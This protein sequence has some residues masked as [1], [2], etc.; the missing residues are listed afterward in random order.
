M[1]PMI[2]SLKAQFRRANLLFYITVI[3]PTIASVLYFGIFASNVY[4][5]E[6]RFIVRSPDKPAMSGLGMLFK[7]AGFSNASDEILAAQNYA[8]S[9][10]ALA[11][12]NRNDEFRKAYASRSISVFDRFDPLGL[13]G[14]FEQMYDYYQTKVRADHDSTS[15][16]TTLTVRAY[17]PDDAQRVNE[18]LL[19]MSEGMVNR[20]NERARIDLVRTTENE[21]LNAKARSQ[22]AALALSAFRNREGVVDPEKQA[23]V[24]IQMVSK[25]QDQLIASQTQLA[26]LRAVTPN[27]PQIEALDAQVNSLSADIDREL[28]KIAGDRKSLSSTAAQYQRLQLETQ[29]ADRQLAA[30]MTS[31]QEAQNESLR[32]HAYVERIVQPNRPD[33]AIEPRRFRGILSTLLFALIAWGV[34]SM[35][36]A[37]VREHAQ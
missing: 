22:A 25:L 3:V 23:T 31:L 16:I 27:N 29:F 37:G 14:S 36:L 26:Q 2:D 15:S 34:L 7:S 32:K 1:R 11:E 20:L 10:D 8:I 18:Q 28:G 12:L 21:V 19:R 5:S 13:S 35:L 24:Q 30:A 4:V 6:S 17:S 9:R 33:H